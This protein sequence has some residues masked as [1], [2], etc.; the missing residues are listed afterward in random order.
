MPAFLLAHVAWTAIVWEIAVRAVETAKRMRPREGARLLFALRLAPAVL[1]GLLVAGV[2]APSYLWLEPERDAEH[3]GLGC[4]LAAAFGAAA[5]L[6]GIV[7]AARAAVR[8]S[9]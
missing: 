9:H 5:W 4:L 8:S 6:H 1:A 7:R 2:C 3:I